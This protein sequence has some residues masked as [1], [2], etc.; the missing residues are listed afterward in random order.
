MPS[1]LDE[2]YVLEMEE[3]PP[4]SWLR[5]AHERII[6][7]D[8]LKINGSKVHAQGNAF[9]TAL[10]TREMVRSMYFELDEAISDPRGEKHVV[11][12]YSGNNPAAL[13]FLE[14]AE[15]KGSVISTG[16][17]LKRLARNRGWEFFSLP[18]G[19]PARFAF[20]ELF[21]CIF[22]ASNSIDTDSIRKKSESLTPTTPTELNEAKR[23]AIGI[24]KGSTLIVYGERR[25]GIARR[26]QE[27]LL[28]N[29][30]LPTYRMSEVQYSFLNPTD[31]SHIIH[32]SSPTSTKL[33]DS[34]LI[35]LSDTIE[36]A[37][38]GSI[39]SAYVSIYISILKK[40][41]ILLLDRYNE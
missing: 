16:G 27:D 11:I 3:S 10:I 4:F 17:N 9:T 26:F 32:I 31:I 14:H 36:D 5:Q 18:K 40:L 6:N 15:G 35:P 13:R 34:F 24:G 39:L 28:Q 38:Y 23:I 21:G 30:S 7:C 33:R 41:E 8:T 2:E 19:M 20:P 25:E 29:A 12:S 37:I 22:G 1:V